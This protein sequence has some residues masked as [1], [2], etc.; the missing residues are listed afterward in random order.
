MPARPTQLAERAIESRP[1]SAAQTYALSLKQPWAAL[2][3]HGR[4]TIEVRRWPTVRRGGILIHAARVPDERAEVWA[5]LPPE[6]RE[7]AALKGGIVGVAELTGCRAYRNRDAFAADQ[8]Q[9]LNPV[10]WFEGTVLYGFTFQNAKPL[11]FQA[12]SGWMRFFPVEL[13]LDAT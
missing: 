7:A 9:H 6:L 3:A 2:L 11:P 1:M 5:L 10:D 12:C 8:L 13:D 4:K